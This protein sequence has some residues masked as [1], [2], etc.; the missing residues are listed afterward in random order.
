MAILGD[1]VERVRAAANIVTVVSP[2][3]ALRRSGRQ[4]VGLCPFH[5]EKSGSFYVNDDKGVFMC[6][7]CQKGGD[8]F[9]FVME[10]EHLGFTEA[11]ERL[12]AQLGITLRYSSGGESEDRKRRKALVAAVGEAAAWYHQR[13]LTAPDAGPAR[14]YLRSRGVSGDEV[15]RFQLGW[16]PDGWDTMVKGLRVPADVLE[17]AGLA[18]RNR[19]GRLTDFFRGRLLFPIATDQGEPVAFGGRILPGADGPKYKNSPESRIY[20]KSRTLYGLHL[21]KQAVVAADEVVVC[22]GYTDVMGFHR[23]GVPRAVATCG[24][25]LTAEHVELLRRFAGRVVLAFDADAAGQNAAARFYEWEKTYGVEVAVLRLPPGTDP[26]E[27]AQRDPEALRAAVEHPLPFLGF[28]VARVLDAARLD[29][30]EHRARAADEA[31]AVI[32]EHP[33]PIVRREY[34]GQVAMRTGLDAEHLVRLAERGGRPPVR[35]VA[36]TTQD[37]AVRRPGAVDRREQVVLWLLVHRWDDTAP[38]VVPS[39]FAHP[40]A[41][42]ALDA[43]VLADGDV[44]HAVAAASTDDPEVAAL[45]TRLATADGEADPGPDVRLLVLQAAEREL[46]T[47]RS[48]CDGVV[49]PMEHTEVQGWITRVRDG[50]A[51][52]EAMERLLGWLEF[53]SQQRHEREQHEDRAGSTVPV[54]STDHAGAVP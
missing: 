35:A 49:E 54:G 15:R 23:A 38:L 41:R 42:R 1:D 11:V 36:V 51:G 17:E 50:G 45:L 52:S 24:T 53:R 4:W 2:Y 14:G 33:N 30:P 25:A 32:G 47:W 34:A 48:S 22:E 16:A 19:S 5:A 37:G 7:G 3:V 28:R 12:A 10:I 26:A 13:L 44:Q 46:R 8:V 39:L 18:F 6:H 31:L 43:L 40:V 9:R 21:A 27:L 29:T 20:A